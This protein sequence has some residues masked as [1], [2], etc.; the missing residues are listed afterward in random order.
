[1]SSVDDGVRV[2]LHLHS[3]ASGSATN[4]W[5]KGLGEDGGVR[6]SYTL[7]EESYSMAKRAGM[8]FVTLTDHETIAG[9]NTL[10]HHPDFLVGEEVSALFPEDGSHVDVLLYG[11]DHSAHAEA[12]A[13]RH[14]VYELV[15]YL[16]EAGIVHV[17]AH[18]VYSIA[19]SLDRAAVEKRLVLFSLWEFVNGSRPA[20]QN[21]LAR[22]AAKSV[23]AL[24]LRQMAL[25]H[26]LRVPDHTRVAGT[27]G[28]DDHGGIYGGSTFTLLPRPNPHTA[29]GRRSAPLRSC[30]PAR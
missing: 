16:R 6:E 30:R 21:R 26:G 14:S 12:Q 11:L 22:D 1:M 27:G 2:D 25:R 20:S 4:V 3:R 18:P 13:R 29:P 10:L 5:V 24:D 19:T 28:S 23:R 9:A 17:L 8:D 7:P 15:A